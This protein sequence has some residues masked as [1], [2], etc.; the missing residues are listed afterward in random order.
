MASKSPKNELAIKSELKEKKVEPKDTTSMLSEE[1]DGMKSTNT[2][3]DLEAYTEDVF[4]D[5][6]FQ[7]VLENLEKVNHEFLSEFL[8]KENDEFSK[9]LLDQIEKM[10]K[11]NLLKFKK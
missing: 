5:P 1:K 9:S 2:I 11:K 7:P 8:E 3:S 4:I 10:I 6:R